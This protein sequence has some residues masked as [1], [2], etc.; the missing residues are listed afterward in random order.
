MSERKETCCN[1]CGKPESLVD[2]MLSAG[3]V[4]ICNECV[5]YCYEMLYGPTP[6]SRAKS[7]KKSNSSAKQIQLKKPADM[8]KI[9]QILLKDLERRCKEQMDIELKVRDTVKE[10]LVENSFDSKY[11]ARP[12]KR[13][14]QSKIE[15]PLAEAILNGEVKKGD[16]VAAGMNKKEITFKVLEKK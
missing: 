5:C 6:Q 11:G 13:A 1:F 10:Y 14:I 12:L 4:H 15:D 16:T 7:G 9:L 3:D 2:S 8:K